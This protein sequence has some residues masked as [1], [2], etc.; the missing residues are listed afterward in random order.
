[1]PDEK[2]ILAS[3]SA[4]RAQI[5]RNAGLIFDVVK[6]TVD[7]ERVKARLRAE[8]HPP[9]NQVDSLAE[10]KA[11]SVSLTRPGLVI[12]ADQM[13]ACEGQAFDKPSGRA[14]AKAQLQALRGKEHEL[15]TAVVVTRGAQV[16]WR[17]VDRPKLTVRPFSDAFLE[18]YLDRLGEK[19]MTSVGAYQLEGEGAQLFS[20]VEGDFFSV[21]GLP[22]LPL[23]D[24]LRNEGALGA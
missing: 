2:L 1:M 20:K 21:L 7:E 16:L 12:G 10:V 3:G 8:G 17:L 5:L 13:L 18:S 11:M 14:E 22:L 4:S 24:F 23:L 15:M 19:A 6:P 9:L